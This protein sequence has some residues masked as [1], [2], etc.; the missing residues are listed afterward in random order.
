MYPWPLAVQRR[1]CAAFA[2]A[3]RVLTCAPFRRLECPYALPTTA[4]LWMQSSTSSLFPFFRSCAMASFANCSCSAFAFSIVILNPPSV[5][6]ALP[7]STQWHI[8]SECPSS[9]TNKKTC[10][11]STFC[12]EQER[13]AFPKNPR[14]SGSKALG[15]GTGPSNLPKSILAS[16]CHAS[17]NG[18]KKPGS[19]SVSLHRDTNCHPVEREWRD[20]LPP[21]LF[22]CVMPGTE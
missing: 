6:W 4:M 16:F 21:A 18:R 1:Q 17:K 19:R 20:P 3:V 22:F 10:S 15:K 11:N 7:V 12:R 8:H 13:A 2:P 5:F 14:K 9:N